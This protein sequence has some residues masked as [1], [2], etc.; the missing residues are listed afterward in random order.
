MKETFK[1]L[2]GFYNSVVPYPIYGGAPY[3][4]ICKVIFNLNVLSPILNILLEPYLLWRGTFGYKLNRSDHKRR[5]NYKYFFVT[6]NRKKMC[7]AYKLV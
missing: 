5:I 4:Y 1:D 3:L 6:Q 7:R 2:N